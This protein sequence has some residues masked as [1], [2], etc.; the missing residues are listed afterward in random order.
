MY[1]VYNQEP[2]RDTIKL[3]FMF[4]TIGPSDDAFTG[5][6]MNIHILQALEVVFTLSALP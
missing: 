1:G 6:A 4:A 2:S 3:R 5:H